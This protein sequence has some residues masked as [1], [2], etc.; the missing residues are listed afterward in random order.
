[1]SFGLAFIGKMAPSFPWTFGLTRTGL[2]RRCPLL[3]LLLEEVLEADSLLIVCQDPLRVHAV[4]DA[5]LETAA[6]AQLLALRVDL[7]VAVYAKRNNQG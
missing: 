4:V 6:L 3:V 5:L 7:T 1:M 2:N